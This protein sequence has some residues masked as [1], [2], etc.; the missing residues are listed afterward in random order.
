[1]SATGDGYVYPLQGEENERELQLAE[2]ALDSVTDELETGVLIARPGGDIGGS[3][4]GTDVLKPVA[5]AAMGGL[6]SS[7][8]ELSG[9]IALRHERDRDRDNRLHL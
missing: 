6:M 3:T 2:D 5:P 8:R 4:M 9:D 1:M 7:A